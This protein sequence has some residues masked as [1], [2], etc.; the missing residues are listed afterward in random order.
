M[1]ISMKKKKEKKIVSTR[2]KKKRRIESIF[3][4]QLKKWA[5]IEFDLGFIKRKIQ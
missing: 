5:F 3:T 4:F 1:K 2:E